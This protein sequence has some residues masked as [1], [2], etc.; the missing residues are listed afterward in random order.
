MYIMQILANARGVLYWLN[1]FV[2]K[3]GAATAKRTLQVLGENQLKPY[4]I[5]ISY[6]KD[7]LINPAPVFG[8]ILY[9]SISTGDISL[10]LVG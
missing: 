4:N 5:I 9:G 7:K 10:S 2:N 3:L 6:C 1:F 8:S